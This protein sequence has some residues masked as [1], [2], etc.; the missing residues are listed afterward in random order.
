MGFEQLPVPVRLSTTMHIARRE[1]LANYG[2]G[3]KA[4][5][6]WNMGNPMFFSHKLSL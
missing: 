5:M 2:G 4:R 1:E 6:H 3:V